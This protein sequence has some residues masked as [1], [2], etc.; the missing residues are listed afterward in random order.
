MVNC[1]ENIWEPDIGNFDIPV[2]TITIKGACECGSI[3]RYDCDW[4]AVCMEPCDLEAELEGCRSCVD[5][6]DLCCMPECED[7]KFLRV[8]DCNDCANK[9]EWVDACAIWNE[10]SNNKD[11]GFDFQIDCSELS[12]LFTICSELANPTNQDIAWFWWECKNGKLQLCGELPQAFTCQEF[13]D[14]ISEVTFTCPQQKCTDVLKDISCFKN[15]EDCP[16]CEECDDD[17]CEYY[18]IEYC[19]ETCDL[20]QKQNPHKVKCNR[21]ARVKAEL[22]WWPLHIQQESGTDKIYY[23]SSVELPVNTIQWSNIS[24]VNPD[25]VLWQVDATQPCRDHCVKNWMFSWNWFNQYI[26]AWTEYVHYEFQWEANKAIH[27]ARMWLMLIPCWETDWQLISQFKLGATVGTFYQSAEDCEFPEELECLINWQPCWAYWQ[28]NTP[29]ILY[30]AVACN[31]LTSAFQWPIGDPLTAWTFSLGRYI[32]AMSFNGW[33][34][35][36][37]MPWDI[38]VPVLLLS[39]DTTWDCDATKTPYWGIFS[40]LGLDSNQWGWKFSSNFGSFGVTDI[41]E[42]ECLVKQYGCKCSATAPSDWAP[43]NCDSL[44][45]CACWD[46]NEPINKCFTPWEATVIEVDDCADAPQ[47]QAD[48]AEWETFVPADWQFFLC[49]TCYT[50]PDTWWSCG[51]DWEPPCWEEGEEFCNE[52]FVL[53]TETNLCE[54]E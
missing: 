3:L 8:N 7:W 26:T 31:E 17:E 30:W 34:Q 50:L 45:N 38:I 23:L 41:Y 32:E 52:W 43:F 42:K 18:D 22:V 44:M 40:I 6:F 13:C 29:D 9:Y 46:I 51:W 4:Y 2:T 1:H 24:W 15:E 19:P 35:V 14:C 28:P 53:N 25:L 5:L 27:A 49:N 33:T 37:V 21:N 48:C 10:I 36:D 47:S 20:R 54:P 16:P 39:A 12:E 11:C